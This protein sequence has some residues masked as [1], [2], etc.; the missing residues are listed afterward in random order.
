[1]HDDN[2]PNA[3]PDGGTSRCVLSWEANVTNGVHQQLDP[4]F[5]SRTQ[6]AAFLSQVHNLPS[7]VVSGD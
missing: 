5:L 2:I 7:S 6:D 1:M 3:W 4:R